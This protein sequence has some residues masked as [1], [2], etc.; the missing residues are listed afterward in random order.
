ML[1]QLLIAFCKLLGEWSR[2]NGLMSRARIQNTVELAAI[3]SLLIRNKHNC[4]CVIVFLAV[5]DKF[6][7][8]SVSYQAE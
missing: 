6:G 8:V 2:R 1:M 7:K 4:F 3:G 5:S